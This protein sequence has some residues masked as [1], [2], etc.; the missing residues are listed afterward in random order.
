MKPKRVVVS[1]AAIA[2]IAGGGYGLYVL[3]VHRGMASRDG[4]ASATG[5]E[6]PTSNNESGEEATRRHLKAGLKSGDVDPATGR[7][8]LYYHDPMAPGRKFDSPGKSP[9]MDMMLVP[10]YAGA[11]Q[12]QG[13]ISVSPRIEQSLGVRTALVTQGSLAPRVEAVGAIAYNE[14]DQVLVQAR[15]AGYI[16]RLY[17]RAAL[18]RVKKDERLAELYVPDWVAAQ[19]EYLSVRRMQGTDLASLIDAA[20]ARMR[21][22]GMTEEQ[23]GLVE[24]SGTVQPGLA[25]V[26]PIGGVVAELT[27]REG[28]TVTAGAA[29]FR[30]NGL[31]TVWANAEVPESQ[32][33]YVRPG[34]P[35]AARSPGVPGT[36][37]KGR[38]QAILPEVNPSTR[39]I[40]ARVELANLAGLLSP[41]MFVT[42]MLSAPSEQP[43]LL[44]PSEAV[45]RTGRRNVVM[46]ADGAGKFRPTE[47]E[48]GLEANS[49]TEIRRGLTVGQKVVV[50]GQFL[51]DSEASL[52]ATEERMAGGPEAAPTAAEHH[53]EGKIEAIG[54]D[55]ITLSHGPIPSMKWGAM[56]MSFG[57]PPSGL[58]KDLKP[59]QSVR[60]SFAPDKDGAPVITHIEPMS[61][62]KAAK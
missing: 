6:A 10:V 17:V 18:D 44:V 50:S 62:T 9:F 3:G 5:A 47:V 8:I 34:A 35:V 57:L 49:Q 41:G 32:A 15:A 42:V 22:A 40:K 31:A 27:A 46:V 43:S 19:E 52:N 33:A 36:T 29:L 11:E 16:E 25:L 61:S 21:Q 54:K 13:G 59:G 56:T 48:V 55:E 30:I 7:K 23:I 37:F 12:D 39:T 4:P 28:M 20:R 58:A 24:A 53:G 38:V 2:V 1:L 26:A 45:I 14:R 60:F 51:I